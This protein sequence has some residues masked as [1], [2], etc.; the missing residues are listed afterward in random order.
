VVG[1]YS[2]VMHRHV[3]WEE[4]LQQRLTVAE[5]AVNSKHCSATPKLCSC[6]KKKT[7]KQELLFMHQKR[8]KVFNWPWTWAERGEKKVLSFNPYP[9][10]YPPW[11]LAHA[12]F[13][14]GGTTI[15]SPIGLQWQS[16]LII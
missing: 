11:K 9:T 1:I 13:P 6:E 16:K 15:T 4:N 3:F 7:G 8:A 12:A 10:V 5:W 14:S 2:Q